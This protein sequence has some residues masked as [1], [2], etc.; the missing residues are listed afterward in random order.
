[1][2]FHPDPALRTI[3][4]DIE[5]KALTKV[6]FGDTKEGTFAI[7]L[8]S[9][10]E[11]PAAGQPSVPKRTGKM[12]NAEGAAGEPNV[13]GKRSD[14]V[15]RFGEIGGETIGVAIFDHPSNPRH[16]AYWASRGYGLCA[17]NIFGLRDFEH[18]KTKDGSLTLAPGGLLRFRYRVMVHPGDPAAADVAARYREYAGTK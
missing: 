10:L 17:A 16:P 2:V 8:A 1:M 7:R 18:D 13:W 15:D 4:F 9:W 14:W 12:V 3:D 5:L 11:E 6:M